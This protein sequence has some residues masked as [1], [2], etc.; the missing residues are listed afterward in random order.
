MSSKTKPILI[1]VLAL[2]VITVVGVAPA[3]ASSMET[4]DVAID[5]IVA[6]MEDVAAAAEDED[7]DAMSDAC[8]Q[9]ELDAGAALYHTRPKAIPRASWRHLRAAWTYVE[10]G[11]KACSEGV[12]DLD[13]DKL[14]LSAE[15]FAEA[16]R[17][18]KAATRAL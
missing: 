1:G 15:L 3:G 17:E 11:A 7:R 10:D 12:D 5:H 2:A 13:P 4:I 16:N 14:T 9:L 6:D 8:Y 18:T